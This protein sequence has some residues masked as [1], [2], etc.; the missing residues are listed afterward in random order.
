MILSELEQRKKVGSNFLR[1]EFNFSLDNDLLNELF[2]KPQVTKYDYMYINPKLGDKLIGNQKCI[3]RKAV[4]RAV[5][6]DGIEVD[7]VANEPDMGKDFANRRISRKAE[8]Y[9]KS[10]IDLNLYVCYYDNSPIG[11]CEFMLNDEIAKIEDFD[12]LKKY[13]R[14]GF[15]TSVIKHLLNEAN[16]REI[17]IVYLITDSEDTAKEMYKKCGFK[18][19]V[20][21]TELFFDLS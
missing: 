6:D 1:V 11:N 7:I 5:L 21:K 9:K 3:I 12:I 13:Q 19:A 2:I 10:D 8:V 4:S 15:G 18:K 16:K 20:E 17:D 14:M